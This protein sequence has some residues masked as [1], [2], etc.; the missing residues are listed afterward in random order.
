MGT[1]ICLDNLDLFNF[2]TLVLKPISKKVLEQIA[3]DVQVYHLCNFSQDDVKQEEKIRKDGGKYILT[4]CY[5]TANLATTFS[6]NSDGS[7]V[8]NHESEPR[9]V[10]IMGTTTIVDGLFVCLD[11]IMN[12][13]KP[14]VAGLTVDDSDDDDSD[15]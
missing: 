12:T 1:K 3:S 9:K 15:E 7:I 6:K 11:D 14:V 8:W 5:G 4:K 13:V 2:T 10:M